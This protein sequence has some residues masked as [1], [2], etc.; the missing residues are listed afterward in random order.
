MCACGLL[1]IPLQMRKIL[2]PVARSAACMGALSIARRVDIGDALPC[3]APRNR[4]LEILL[5]LQR[6]LQQPHAA[7]FSLRLKAE[8]AAEAH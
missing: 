7:L 4:R 5:H 3:G 8:P 1:Q 6:N 2:P